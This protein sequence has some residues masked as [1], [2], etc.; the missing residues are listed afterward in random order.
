MK[1]IFVFVAGLL[2]TLYL[3]NPTAGIFELIPDNIPFVGNLDEATA[4]F[5]LIESLNYFGFNLPNPFGRRLK[6]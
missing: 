1:S 6:K 2:S 4:A 5:F 3:I